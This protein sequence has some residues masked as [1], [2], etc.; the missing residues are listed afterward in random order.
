MRIALYHNLGS[1]GSKRE[2]YEFARSLINTGHTVDVFAPSTA[3]DEFLPLR[4]LC[5]NSFS[6]PLTLN[7]PVR[8]RLPG[9]RRYLDFINLL[10]N[11]GKQRKLSQKIAKD[12]DTGNYDFAFVHHDRIVQSPFLLRYLRTPAYYF[13]AE[14]MRQFYEPNI[15]RNYQQPA[16]LAAGLQNA[17]YFPARILADRIIRRIDRRN[18]RHATALLTN[19][20]FS[21]ESVYRAYEMRARV[22]YLGVDAD[23]FRNLNL[24]RENFVLSVGAVAPLKGYDFL[25]AALGELPL[26]NRPELYIV[27]NTVSTGEMNFLQ[28]LAAEKGVQVSFFENVTEDELVSFYNRALLFVYSAI[29]EPFGLTPVEAMA[30]GTPVVGVREGG[31]R[32]SVRD[33]ETGYLT[34]REPALFAEKAQKLLSDRA[35]WELFSAQARQHVEASWTW[36]HACERFIAVIQSIRRGA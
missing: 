33:G 18:I 24:V 2:A 15:T 9:L 5:E 20:Y 35:R 11:L 10:A 17:W 22:V 27:G 14:P 1:G 25:I 31:V 21:A 8:M 12:I 26:L 23:K 6:Y 19:S 28:Q 13:C 16:G 34:D 29:L 3:D 7:P 36:S 30:C 4:D 32:E